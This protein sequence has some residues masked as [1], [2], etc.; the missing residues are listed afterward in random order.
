MKLMFLS[1][2]FLCAI[3]TQGAEKIL[4][5]DDFSSGKLDLKKWRTNNWRIVDD[6][7]TSGKKGGV[8]FSKIKFGKNRYSIYR[9]DIYGYKSRQVNISSDN[10]WGM[11][12]NVK[13][14][15]KGVDLRLYKNTPY[16]QCM[17][18]TSELYSRKLSQK[19]HLL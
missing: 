6:R 17:D 18:T 9:L 4:L 14:Y 16:K 5:D 15:K 11:V 10:W 1:I 12:P 13:K 8:L 7:A 3:C 19:F 2:I